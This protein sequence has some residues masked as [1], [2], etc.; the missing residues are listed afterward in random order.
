[1]GQFYEVESRRPAKEY[2]PRLKLFGRVRS[3]TSTK[4]S[5]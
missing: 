1:V 3:R 4:L 2:R 5:R